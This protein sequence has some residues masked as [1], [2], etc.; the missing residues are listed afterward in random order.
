CKTR[1]FALGDK[2]NS[3]FAPEGKPPR[4][5]LNPRPLACGNN[6]SKVTLGEQKEEEVLVQEEI[7]HIS[8]NALNGSNSF[9]TMRVT[10]IIGKHELHILVNGRFTYNFLDEGVCRELR[11]VCRRVA[12][13]IGCQ[14]KGTCPLAVIV[15]GGRQLISNSECKG[16]MWQLQGETFST[17]MMILPPGSYEM[18]LGIQWLATLGDI[19][20]N[21]KQLGMEFVHKGKNI[22]LKGTPKPALHWMEGKR[23][24]NEVIVSSNAELLM[25]RNQPV[26]IRL[27]RHPPT[28]K[29]A[30]E[31]M[32]KE[33]LKAGVIK[34][35]NSP[36]ASPIVIV[37]KKDNTWRICIDYRQLNKRTINDNF[38]IPI[39]EELIDE[40]GGATVFSN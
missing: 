31:A 19:K 16:F 35:S 40:L 23:Q 32:V 12:K 15:R 6:L 7:P 33:L 9:Q 34:P 18:V 14:P 2:P 39:I 38:S 25:L 28:Q 27:Y 8:L 36:F 4:R 13:K 26:N 20:C 5:G 37:K 17:D 29:D 3:F 22:T 30:I 24:D 11:I 21:F 1:T 10:G